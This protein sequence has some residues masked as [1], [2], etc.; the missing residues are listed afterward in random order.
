MLQQAT[1]FRDESVALASLLA[2]LPDSAFRL[3]TGFKDW[4]IENV[5]QH[6]HHLN[7]VAVLSLQDPAAFAE[8]AAQMQAA[9]EGGKRLIDFQAEW[10]DGLAGRALFDAWRDYV[11]ETATAFGAADPS[12]RVKWFGP[13]MSVRSSITARLM[14]T[15]AH[16][17]EV[18]DVLGVVRANTDRIRNI[19]VIGV[20]T[21]GW[22]FANRGEAVPA[23]A[24][25]VRLVAPSGAVWTFN[26][27]SAEER[28]EGSAEA[29]C[30]VVT[31]V[32]NVADTDLRT[33]GANA[34]AWMSK[35]QC[36]A[37]APQEPPAPLTRRTAARQPTLA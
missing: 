9:R 35:A 24:P 31:Q 25:H 7:H 32:R 28:V 8:H 20:N 4:T 1:D 13:D 14:E 36:F 27:E 6:V 5:L 10:L 15:W 2:P 29:F 11:E 30:Q 22:T 26:D 3:V 19:A 16:G 33:Q 23:P 12:A 18:Y 34:R 37:G 21:Y 17:Q